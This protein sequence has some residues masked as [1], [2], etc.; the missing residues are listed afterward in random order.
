MKGNKRIQTVK[1]TSGRGAKRTVGKISSTFKVRQ[2]KR[3]YNH[4][5]GDAAGHLMQ[6]KHL[7]PG[8][9][10]DSTHCPDHPD[11]RNWVRALN[12]LGICM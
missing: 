1:W 5:E 3:R 4:E 2:V 9:D 11:A 7:L 10:H 12:G 6:K 8:D